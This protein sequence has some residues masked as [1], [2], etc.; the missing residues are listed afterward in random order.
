[1]DEFLANV[2]RLTGTEVAAKTI[3]YYFNEY[4]IYGGFKEDC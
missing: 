3:R 2:I 4:K 1:M